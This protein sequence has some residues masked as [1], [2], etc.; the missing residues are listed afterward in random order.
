[1]IFLNIYVKRMRIFL[2]VCPEMRKAS[3]AI[4]TILLAGCLLFS[5]E[6]L[7]G[8]PLSASA[9]AG[10]P[11]GYPATSG[12]MPLMRSPLSLLFPFGAFTHHDVCRR[13]FYDL[14]FT[15]TWLGGF[16]YTGMFFHTGSAGSGYIRLHEKLTF[17]KGNSFLLVPQSL[18]LPASPALPPLPKPGMNIPL[19]D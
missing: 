8:S 6:M 14:Q 9:A 7:S 13:P 19:P 18:T 12:T 15:S 1:V 5:V 16:H 2:Y 10:A 3:L 11:S 4:S 17:Q